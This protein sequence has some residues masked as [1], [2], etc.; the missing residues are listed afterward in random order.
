MNLLPVDDIRCDVENN[1]CHRHSDI[2]NQRQTTA[3]LKSSRWLVGK[4]AKQ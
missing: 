2:I 3:D 1:A 4:S